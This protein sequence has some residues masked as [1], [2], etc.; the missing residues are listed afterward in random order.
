M[1][2]EKAREMMR[3]MRGVEVSEATVRRHTE[4]NGA[5]YV[6]VQEAAVERI[7][8]ELP[9]AP[10]GPAK[11]LLSVDGVKVPLVGGEW[12][13]VKTLV[14]GV[15]LSACGG[16]CGEDRGRDLGRRDGGDPGLA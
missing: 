11:Q 8:R 1:P 5:V 4:G 15:G 7:E 12:A 2:F 6:A 10:A 14:L 9:E 16:I 13:E 3:R